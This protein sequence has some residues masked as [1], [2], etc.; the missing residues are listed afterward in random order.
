MGVH[1]DINKDANLPRVCP[2]NCL[3]KKLHTL[4]KIDDKQN[5]GGDEG[6]RDEYSPNFRPI[7]TLYDISKDNKDWREKKLNS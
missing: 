3:V 1:E 7:L 2:D 6:N 5:G 4:F